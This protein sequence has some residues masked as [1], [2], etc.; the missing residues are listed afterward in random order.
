MNCKLT[1]VRPLHT[2]TTKQPPKHNGG[3]ER[4]RVKEETTKDK[5]NLQPTEPGPRCGIHNKTIDEETIKITIQPIYWDIQSQSDWEIVYENELEHHSLYHSDSEERR[6]TLCNSETEIEQYSL[7]DSESEIEQ[8][9]LYDSES[10]IEQYNLYDS[11]SEMYSLHDS[12]SE[13]EQYILPC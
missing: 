8:Y 10:E 2:P 3:M 1:F 13:V 6:H 7:H 9:S 11:E 4:K 12:E 5:P